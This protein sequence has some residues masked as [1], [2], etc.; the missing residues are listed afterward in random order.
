MDRYSDAYRVSAT[1]VGLG[2]TVKIGGL[3]IAGLIFLM[4]VRHGGFGTIAALP[5]ALVIGTGGFVAG[6]MLA[7]VGQ[8]HKAVLDGAVNTSPFL[9]NAQR[10]QIMSISRVPSAN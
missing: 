8:I 7:A 1:V 4:G 5:F 3:V 9:D 10:A 6:T 2:N